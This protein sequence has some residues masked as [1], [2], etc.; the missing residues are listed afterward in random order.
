MTMRILANATV[1]V[2]RPS[3]PKGL[4]M[5]EVSVWGKPPHDWTKTYRIQAKSDTIAA[6]EGIDR[7]V[8]EITELL[9]DEDK[10]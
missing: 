3:T 4:G 8:A 7:F 2:I 10:A 9:Q 1:N 6:R 5:F